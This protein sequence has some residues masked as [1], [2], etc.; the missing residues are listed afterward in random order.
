MNLTV[1][2][3]AR[4][5]V[6]CL[7]N[8][9]GTI[10]VVFYQYQGGAQLI[11]PNGEYD[12]FSN[13]E[14]D[15]FLEREGHIESL[16]NYKFFSVISTS[17]DFRNGVFDEAFNSRKDKEYLGDSVYVQIENKYWIVLTTENGLPEDP[18]NTILLEPEVVEALISYIKRKRDSNEI[19]VI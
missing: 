5:K 9:V 2:D 16:E 15:E 6:Q 4:L 17:Q 3:T 11:F 12:G 18:S 19:P 14:Q 7:K 1:G 8:P 10:G 13:E